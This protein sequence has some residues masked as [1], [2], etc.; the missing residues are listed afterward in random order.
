MSIVAEA[1]ARHGK[2]LTRKAAAES[3]ASTAEMAPAEPAAHVSATEP[4]AHVNATTETAS[5]PTPT[6]MSGG[7]G[8]RR[9][10][11]TEHDGG[12]EDHRIACER[13]LPDVLNEVHGRI[14]LWP[15]L[16]CV[17]VPKVLTEA[18]IKIALL[19]HSLLKE[20]QE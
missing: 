11:C 2:V 17:C 7:Q 8:V 18:Q 3:P 16:E 15:Q 9:H 4:A 20:V 5:V 10:P 6:A 13:L 1:A 19:L 14:L 12:E